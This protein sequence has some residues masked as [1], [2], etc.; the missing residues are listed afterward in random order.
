[1]GRE[2][3]KK[4]EDE[5][6]RLSKLGMRAF[7]LRRP[8]MF[9]ER[10]WHSHGLYFLLWD[11]MKS[12]IKPE[13]ANQCSALNIVIENKTVLSIMDNGRGLPVEPVQLG[14]V[15]HPKIEWVFTNIVTRHPLPAYYKEFGFL[16][17][18]AE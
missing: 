2:D 4:L 11:I 12:A 16:D 14:Y 6:T 8:E 18:M 10:Q 17:Y 9:I 15:E 5:I 7:I 13:Q 1:M 3:E